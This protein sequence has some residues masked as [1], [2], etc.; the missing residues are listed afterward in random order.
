MMPKNITNESIKIFLKKKKIQ[1]RYQNLTEEEKKRN[2]N[3][4]EEQKQKLS[5]NY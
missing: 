2:N 5:K 1:E 3:L 4:S